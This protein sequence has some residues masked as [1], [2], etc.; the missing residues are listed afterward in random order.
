MAGTPCIKWSLGRA[1]INLSGAILFFSLVCGEVFAVDQNKYSVDKA[2][3][4][5]DG[6]RQRLSKGGKLSKEEWEALEVLESI[7][8]KDDIEPPKRRVSIGYQEKDSYGIERYRT[9]KGTQPALGVIVEDDILCEQRLIGNKDGLS[10]KYIR[11][12]KEGYLEK[13]IFL[14]NANPF[15]WAH[16]WKDI[17]RKLHG[18]NDIGKNVKYQLPPSKILIEIVTL[19]KICPSEVSSITG[20]DI[21][22][23]NTETVVPYWANEEYFYS[24]TETTQQAA[25]VSLYYAKRGHLNKKKFAIIWPCY[26]EYRKNDSITRPVQQK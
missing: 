24:E 23:F 5:L 25:T 1:L 6:Y 12:T 10:F 22:I 4:I 18:L 3:Q 15:Y 11:R 16:Y 7:L 2:F 9:I 20:T 21:K 14:K 8:Q 19:A 13:W 26:L 17:D